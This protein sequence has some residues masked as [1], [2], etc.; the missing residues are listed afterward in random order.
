MRKFI[1][2]VFSTWFTFFYSK[3]FLK[4]RSKKA[5]SECPPRCQLLGI[6]QI[7]TSQYLLTWA[8]ILPQSKG[9]SLCGKIYF[10]AA[11]YSCVCL[12]MSKHIHA[13]P[14]AV[15]H[16]GVS[17]Q[18]RWHGCGMAESWRGRHS[19][20]HVLRLGQMSAVS[21]IP[22]VSPPSNQP[23]S[24]LWPNGLWGCDPGLMSVLLFTTGPRLGILFHISLMEGM[25]ECARCTD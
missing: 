14:V 22:K 19:G 12:R 13:L 2:P 25:R 16:T 23:Q 8:K 9:S 21:L 5:S 3:I 11:S 18:A 1:E 15:V 24:H 6:I 17:C 7:F 20:S 10:L 4:G